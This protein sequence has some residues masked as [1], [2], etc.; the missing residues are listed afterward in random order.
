MKSL[1]FTLPDFQGKAPDTIL[2]FMERVYTG[3]RARTA[4]DAGDR[5]LLT[6][7]I[8]NNRLEDAREAAYV[9]PDYLLPDMDSYAGYLTVSIRSVHNWL[10]FLPKR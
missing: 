9:N 1:D 4:I 3:G 7:L 5:L 6:P 2:N 10:M 8:E